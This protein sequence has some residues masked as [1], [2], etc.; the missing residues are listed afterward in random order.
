MFSEDTRAVPVKKS[1]ALGN[2]N[3]ITWQCGKAQ[4]LLRGIRWAEEMKLCLAYVR[5]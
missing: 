4:G 1:G 5:I 3:S 2:S